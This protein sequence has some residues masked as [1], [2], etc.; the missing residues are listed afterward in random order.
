MI[1]D[2]PGD[3]AGK[4]W[5]YLTAAIAAGTL[6]GYAIARSVEGD[7]PLTGIETRR[8]A[9]IAQAVAL[10]DK[11]GIDVDWNTVSPDGRAAKASL[12]GIAIGAKR[13]MLKSWVERNLP[14]GLVRVDQMPDAEVEK[15]FATTHQEPVDLQ[16]EDA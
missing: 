3:D 6:A 15:L 14:A 8:I 11:F 16:F 10:K 1:L 4:W 7:K 5:L 12:Q 9:R 2:F 13:A